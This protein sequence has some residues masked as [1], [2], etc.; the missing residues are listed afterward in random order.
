MR[1]KRRY[2]AASRRNLWLGLAV[3]LL[4]AAAGVARWRA[5]DGAAVFAARGRFAGATV[6][7]SEPSRLGRVD[8][9]SLRNEEG[10]VARA[11]YRRP[12]ELADGYRLVVL[13]AGLKTERRALELLPERPDVALVV[14]EYPYE[15]PRT[16]AGK[17]RWLG[18]V[19]RAAARTVA[20][21]MLALSYL[22]EAGALDLE[23]TVVVGASLGS[24]FATLHGALDERVPRVVLVHGG[25]DFPRL[26]PAL[27]R[28]WWQVP[29]GHVL[30][31]GPFYSFDPIH[32]VG[33][34][35]PREL[36]MV[37][38]RDDER[39]PPASTTALYE[40]AGEPKRLTWTESSHVRSRN[41]PLVDELVAH[42]EAALPPG[43]ESPPARSGGGGRGR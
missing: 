27:A 36:V 8:R 13:Y 15:R 6:V 22:E 41:R 31:A 20:G 16:L 7:A 28:S 4:G 42:I 14:V 35:A 9:L 23:R 11:L 18:D 33:R 19:R 29:L 30:A 43:G 38:A 5:T 32:Y 39:F 21:G 17:L 2:G 3:L 37:A 25:G 12:R 24:I 10:E 34:I 26:V 40:R 1:P